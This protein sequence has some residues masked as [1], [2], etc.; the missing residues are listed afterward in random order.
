MKKDFSKILTGIA[1]VSFV[2]LVFTLLS[3][4][5]IPPKGVNAVFVLQFW[6]VSILSLLASLL[7]FAIFKYVSKKTHS[8]EKSF[9]RWEIKDLAVVLIPLTPIVQY[10]FSNQDILNVSNSFSLVAFF[11]VISLVFCLIIPIVFSIFAEKILLQISG[12]G[13]L[14]IMF[15]MASFSAS[16]HWHEVG[17][18]SYQIMVTAIVLAALSGIFIFLKKQS[19]YVFIVFFLVNSLSSMLSLN[20]EDSSDN[21][22]QEEISNYPL[23]SETKNRDLAKTNDVIF[24][25]YEAYANNETMLKYGIN[26]SAQ[27]DYLQHKGFTLYDDAYSN[28]PC[29]HSSISGV[30]S[31]GLKPQKQYTNKMYDVSKKHMVGGAAQTLL[32][33]KGYKSLGV[34]HTDTFFRGLDRKEIKYD[35]FFPSV[36][37]GE[38]SLLIN[39]ILEGEFRHEA[40][41]D[42]I[43]YNSYVA[44]KHQVLSSKNLSPYLL[45]SHSTV[46][47]HS[48]NSGRC[49][50]NE[51]KKY[52]DGIKK[53]NIEMQN[54]IEIILKSNPN[55]IIIVA[56]DHG[57]YLR[58]NCAALARMGK[59]LEISEIDRY[60]IQDR[61]GLFL[62]IKWPDN[63]SANKYDI[64]IIQDT[65]PAIFSYLFD[66]DT[67]FDKTRTEQIT[68]YSDFIT[69]G[70]LVKDGIIVG[71]KD[72]GKTL[73]SS[74]DNE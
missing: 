24:L 34:F 40:G 20:T 30:F 74:D 31:V 59:S 18:F 13:F 10:V 63:S 67:L 4:F 12:A 72:N 55:A 47:G 65:F 14:Y 46:P 2:L 35:Y 6:K 11:A 38:T 56:G 22:L 58:K 39:S 66:D 69:K 54:D 7:C 33:S 15:S 23:F 41:Y 5:V 29:T 3:L 27:M 73:F 45:Y 52:F 60:D 48:Q 42:K 19:H 64:K 26:N 50:P 53:A 28:G 17:D 9:E 16:K 49:M 44:K 8:Y 36:I 57:P 32:Q 1:I 70:V 37:G 61:Y 71:G 62:A 43:D 21:N 68:Q 25:A 51:T